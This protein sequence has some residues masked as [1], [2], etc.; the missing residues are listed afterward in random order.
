V[1][2]VIGHERVR[3]CA[4]VGVPGVNR[5]VRAEALLV[6][7]ADGSADE[8]ADALRQLVRRRLGS[9]KTARAFRVV[10]PLPRDANGELQ[11]DELRGWR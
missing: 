4:I 10:P 1:S 11:R 3:D 8:L 6:A 2:S 9:R 7:D 5:L